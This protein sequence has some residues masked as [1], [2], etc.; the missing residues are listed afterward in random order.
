MRICYNS[1]NDTALCYVKKIF[2]KGERTM[3]SFNGNMGPADYRAIMG[4]NNSG[5]G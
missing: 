4:G 3:S 1:V 2:C 5:W